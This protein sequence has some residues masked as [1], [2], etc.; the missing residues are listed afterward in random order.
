MEISAKDF[1]LENIEIKDFNYTYINKS[2]SIYFQDKEIGEVQG[3]CSI[4]E[5]CFF[6]EKLFFDI[7]ILNSI[8]NRCE[9]LSFDIKINNYFLRNAMF[10]RYNNFI[11]VSNFVVVEN[12]LMRFCDINLY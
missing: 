2:G 5:N 10:Y 9:D 3:F 7:S 11:Y 12:F 1:Q 4:Q 8:S 6:G